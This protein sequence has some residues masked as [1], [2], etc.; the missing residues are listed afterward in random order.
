M[1]SGFEELLARLSTANVDYVLVGGL[2]VAFCGY[3]RATED[4]DIL[5]RV[6]DENI[7][8]LLDVLSEFGEGSARELQMAD[9][10][11]EEGAIRIVEDFPLDIFTQ[12]SG[13]RYEDLEGM[14]E[15]RQLNDHVIRYLNPEGL[16]A[17]KEE[18]VRPKDQTD[19]Q[20]LRRI[21]EE[22]GEREE[23]E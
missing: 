16:I 7:R 2:A 5:V 13:Y 3:V 4:M 10:T 12:M 8:R 19:V 14:T 1:T 18:S 9:F 20:V 15:I 23:G 11:I 21:R 6:D 22:R 17:L